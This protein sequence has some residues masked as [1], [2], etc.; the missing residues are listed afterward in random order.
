M[1]E[2][3]RSAQAGELTQQFIQLVSLLAQQASASL[4]LLEDPRGG[5]PQVNL[6]YA[7]LFID[8]LSMLQEKTRGNLSTE[9][10]GILRNAISNLQMAYVEVSG[11]RGPQPAAARPGADQPAV[12]AA[13]GSGGAP[14][15]PSAA[16]AA[17][18]SAVAPAPTADEE[19]A[20]ATSSPAAGPVPPAS[21]AGTEERESKKR[22]T[23]SYG[24]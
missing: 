20:D 12:A 18:P 24:S 21:L 1:A 9:E 8:Q 5:E 2:V 6:D 16:T 13:P 3:Q 7:R 17:T 11:G 4:G 19:P 10:A 22:F 14:T 15:P 23:K